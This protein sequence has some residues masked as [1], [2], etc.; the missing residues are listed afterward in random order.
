MIEMEVAT[1][2]FKL[3]FTGGFLLAMLLTLLVI[4]VFF[5]MR[6]WMLRD[7]LKDMEETLEEALRSLKKEED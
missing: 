2:V 7:D 3:S 6:L 1:M 4:C 5:A